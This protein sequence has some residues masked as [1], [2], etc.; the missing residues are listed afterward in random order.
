MYEPGPNPEGISLH[1]LRGPCGS[2]RLSGRK[3]LGNSK[4]LVDNACE[5]H[6]SGFVKEELEYTSAVTTKRCHYDLQI[7]Q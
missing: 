5:L 3:T 2:G 6:A 4:D 7:Q 1:F